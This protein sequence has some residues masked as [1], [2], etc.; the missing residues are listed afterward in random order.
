M[1]KG[2]YCVYEFRDEVGFTFSVVY[3]KENNDLQVSLQI[4]ALAVAIGYDFG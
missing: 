4:G 1:K 2:F 3:C